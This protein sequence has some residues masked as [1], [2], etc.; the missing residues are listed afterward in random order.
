[1]LR[2]SEYIPVAQAGELVLLPLPPQD[3]RV[4]DNLDLRVAARALQHNLL[5]FIRINIIMLHVL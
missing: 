1:M 4:A 5:D 3:L 2:A